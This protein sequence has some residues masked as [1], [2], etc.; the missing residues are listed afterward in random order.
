M[1]IS[2]AMERTPTFEVS[3]ER[4]LTI[5]ASVLAKMG[6]LPGQKY[7]AL[8]NNGTIRLIPLISAE[9][10]HGSM[11]GLDTTIDREDDEERI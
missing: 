11:P 4:E 8:T 1:A 2:E 9:E 7:V 5:P 10:A 3:P 6:V